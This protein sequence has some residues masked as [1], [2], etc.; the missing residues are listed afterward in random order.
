MS[1]INTIASIKEVHREYVLLVKIGN[2]Y[3]CYGRDAYIISYLLHYKIN[4]IEKNMYACSFPQTAY[5]K[6]I[7]TLEEKKVNYI[8]LDRRNNYSVDEK[9]S[10]NN[11][12]K[13]NET[14]LKAKEELAT[15]MRI[16]K[17]YRYLLDN[18]RDKEI[19]GEM[20]KIIN[21]RRKVQSN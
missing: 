12:N 7:T 3:Y 14:Y 6:V 2:F 16:E 20:E 5:N 4:I 13:Y 17:I 1:I 8:V 18:T 11:L 15:R 10:N 9:S 21:E 19:I